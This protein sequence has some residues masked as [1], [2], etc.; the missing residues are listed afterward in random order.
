LAQPVAGLANKLSRQVLA[1]VAN[2]RL[3]GDWLHAAF[4]DF[5]TDIVAAI[6]QPTARAKRTGCKLAIL[7]LRSCLPTHP[8]DLTF[9][10]N[11]YLG[12]IR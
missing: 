1:L 12:A 10:Y 8:A 6:G 3:H 11:A 4:R 7:D 2:T 9:D 5:H